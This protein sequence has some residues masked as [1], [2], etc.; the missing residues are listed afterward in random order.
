[1]SRTTRFFSTAAS[2]TGSFPVAL[3][4]CRT[5]GADRAARLGTSR[6]G[7]AACREVN[8]SFMVR[9]AFV[10]V[11]VRPR[12]ATAAI[13]RHSRLCPLRHAVRPAF[14]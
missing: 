11:S 2:R 13:L 10:A 6:P 1:V 12:H 5:G 7:A 8:P 4:C 9:R 14:M 3:L